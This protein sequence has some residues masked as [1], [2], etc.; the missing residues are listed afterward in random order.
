MY[1]FMSHFL[2]FLKQVLQN[3]GYIRVGKGNSWSMVSCC[4]Q[5]KMTCAVF[6][7]GGFLLFVATCHGE[8]IHDD[9]M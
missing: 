1:V 8:F 4:K 3:R 5:I 6:C 9:G 2:L 7:L